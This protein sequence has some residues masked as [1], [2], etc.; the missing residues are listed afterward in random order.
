MYIHTYV[1]CIQYISI[2]TYV[3][4]SGY[5][6]SERLCA[7]WHCTYMYVLCALSY[8]VPAY[9]PYVCF[10]CVELSC[11]CC[12]YVQ[13]SLHRQRELGSITVDRTDVVS[14]RPAGPY[15]GLDIAQ[16]ILFLGGLPTGVTP[17]GILQPGETVGG[18][19]CIASLLCTL[20]TCIHCKSFFLS[21]HCC[22]FAFQFGDIYIYIDVHVGNKKRLCQAC[23]SS[24][25]LNRVVLV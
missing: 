2:A 1:Y 20:T 25:Q 11:T 3:C 6:F 19:L 21:I 12:M 15:V 24:S 4:I 10:L 22:S 9:I 16:E 13:V 8:I 5:L 23:F 14:G 17:R 7:H 18:T